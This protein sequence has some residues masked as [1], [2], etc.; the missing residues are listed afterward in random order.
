MDSFDIALNAFHEENKQKDTELRNHLN[1]LISHQGKF[2]QKFKE[3]GEQ[4]EI[5]TFMLAAL[6]DHNEHDIQNID[7]KYSILPNS[8]IEDFLSDDEFD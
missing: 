6:E 4:C 1:D 7:S 8:V 2:L 3:Q 5:E